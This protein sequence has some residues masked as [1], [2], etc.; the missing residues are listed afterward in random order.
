MKLTKKYLKNLDK[1]RHHVLVCETPATLPVSF[2][3]HTYVITVSGGKVS[4][5]DVVHHAQEESPKNYLYKDYYEAH[6]GILL[7]YRKKGKGKGLRFKPRI[8]THTTYREDVMV[9]K[10]EEV[11]TKYPY[12]NTYRFWGPN[13]NTFVSWLLREVGVD[14]ELPWN[15]LGRSYGKDS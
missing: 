13:C 5:Y 1:D 11:Y 15:A 2:V 4:R 8:I 3:A 10:I 7:F 12:K 9:K 14:Q 6:E